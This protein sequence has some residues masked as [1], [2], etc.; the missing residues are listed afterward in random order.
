MVPG[1]LYI[2][3]NVFQGSPRQ[4]APP[5]LLPRFIAWLVEQEGSHIGLS[6]ARSTMLH[7]QQSLSMMPLDISAWNGRRGITVGGSVLQAGHSPTPDHVHVM[8]SFLLPITPEMIPQIFTEYFG[9]TPGNIPLNARYPSAWKMASD[10]VAYNVGL[11]AG[12][13]DQKASI[14]RARG[15]LQC[16]QFVVLML[17][18]YCHAMPPD[19]IRNELLFK[20]RDSMRRGCALRPGNV[21]RIL[22]D[23]SKRPGS[24][25][26]GLGKDAFLSSASN[27][28]HPLS[29]LAMP[30][31]GDAS[32]PVATAISAFG[33][34]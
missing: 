20:L 34:V 18:R 26:T 12:F 30:D 19:L 10:A 21:A 5:G 14:T 2:V 13:D 17:H 24:F 16:A 27:Y 4:G 11:G 7:N 28:V 22:H 31:P 3:V 32:V 8:R 23:I 6:L 15:P 1:Q 33:V 25:V 29:A 9:G